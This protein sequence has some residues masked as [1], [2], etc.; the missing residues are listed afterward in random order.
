[1]ANSGGVR[2]VKW[3][4]AEEN[5]QLMPDDDS[6][7]KDGEF[8]TKGKAVLNFIDVHAQESN[9]IAEKLKQRLNFTDANLNDYLRKS[10]QRQE[11]YKNDLIKKIPEVS[12]KTF[13]N[14]K[15]DLYQTQRVAHNIKKNRSLTGKVC[16]K[17]LQEAAKNN[18]L[19]PQS[20]DV[21]EEPEVKTEIDQMLQIQKQSDALPA[22]NR[23]QKQLQE[24]VVPL[25][26]K[27]CSWQIL[28]LVDE[29]STEI[30]SS[31][32]G[33]Y[34]AMLDH[35]ENSVQRQNKDL[36][37]KQM[38]TL[39]NDVVKNEM[40]MIKLMFADMPQLENQLKQH[41]KSIATEIM[42]ENMIEL[43]TFYE[44]ESE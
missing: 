17:I 21:T 3:G 18:K 23:A 15:H 32:K 36:Y 5:D 16:Q 20:V 12:E 25:F 4:V 14:N 19:A 43:E 42:N 34:A 24:K 37:I 7:V 6:I 26:L 40:E 2:G 29:S 38:K 30:R 1:M 8:I 41:L 39:M 33:Q 31:L 22:S 35:V 27:Y 44:S 11:K 13:S 10:K 9:L 28:E